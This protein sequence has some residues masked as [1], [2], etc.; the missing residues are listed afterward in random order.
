V[1]QAPSSP[2]LISGI[3]AMD[4]VQASGPSP[5]TGA[6]ESED[7]TMYD[8]PQEKSAPSSGRIAPSRSSNAPA[9][10]PLVSQPSTGW[11]FTPL[12]STGSGQTP[13]SKPVASV[14][15]LFGSGSMSSTTSSAPF[16]SANMGNFMDPNY[17]ARFRSTVEEL[18]S[19]S[20]ELHTDLKGILPQMIR[21]Q[22][23]NKINE[24]IRAYIREATSTAELANNIQSAMQLDKKHI[25]ITETQYNTLKTMYGM[26]KRLGKGLSYRKLICRSPANIMMTV[27]HD[28]PAI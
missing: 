15:P 8:A 20:S 18:L 16:G 7:R 19:I 24:K 9:S 2:V 23:A 13:L 5:A 17:V 6:S 3:D 12:K 4:D 27:P 28:Q 1:Q 14:S 11:T 10:I 21:E 25:F 22:D 26:L